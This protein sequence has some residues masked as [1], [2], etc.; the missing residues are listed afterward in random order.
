MCWPHVRP[1]WV[2]VLWDG[3]NVAGR[4]VL[5]GFQGKQRLSWFD[6][7]V[8]VK[9]GGVAHRD[10]LFSIVICQENLDVH[11]CMH[12]CALWLP[13]CSFPVPQV[14]ASSSNS[15]CWGDS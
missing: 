14:S 4:A 9:Y 3:K 12:I 11:E 8:N 5:S 15:V 10:K 13:G 6:L 7:E 2:P 1:Y